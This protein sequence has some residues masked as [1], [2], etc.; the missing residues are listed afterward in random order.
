MQIRRLN[1]RT[2]LEGMRACIIQLQDF[3]RDLD[4]RMPSGA[5]IVEDYLLDLF[6]RCSQYDGRILVADVSAQVAG[7]VMILTRFRSDEI[8]DGDLE[9]G[10]VGDVVVHEA[11]RRQGI[12]R[13]LLAAA[14]AHAVERRVR[15]LRIGVLAC[16]QTA[17]DLYASLG[18]SP[19]A[20]HLEKALA[21]PDA[22]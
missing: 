11:F 3:E 6:Q 5:E 19:Y 18:F 20:I 14:E 9:V 7:Y 16:N 2:D 22:D 12:A 17:V 13:A 21:D 15:W 4:P 10:L 1:R 8:E